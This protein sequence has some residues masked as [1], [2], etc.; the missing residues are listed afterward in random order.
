[1]TT[2][3]RREKIREL[4]DEAKS[5]DGVESSGFRYSVKGRARQ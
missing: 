2:P 4:I 5:K 1:M 3:E